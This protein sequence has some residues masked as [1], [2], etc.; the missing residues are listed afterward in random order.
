MKNIK[1][2]AWEPNS[3]VMYPMAMVG[4]PANPSVW[5]DKNWRECTEAVVIMQFTGLKDKKGVEIYE[6]DIVG[7]EGVYHFIERDGWKPSAGKWKIIGEKSEQFIHGKPPEKYIA[8]YELTEVEWREESC[9][10]EPFSDS[11]E[12]CG[13][14]GGGDNPSK[15]EVIG[16]IYEDAN[17]LNKLLK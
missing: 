17:L 6:G 13:H 2:R 4:E 14:C 7:K 15:L 11:L 12:N 8:G 10:F 16:N 1:F 5:T 3:K 9:G